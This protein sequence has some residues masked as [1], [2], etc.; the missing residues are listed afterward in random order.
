MLVCSCNICYYNFQLFIS[1]VM[2][3]YI[4]VCMN[5]YI[6]ICFRLGCRCGWILI[7]CKFCSNGAKNLYMLPTQFSFLW[8]CRITF[9]SIYVF[10]FIFCW[11][12][13]NTLLFEKTSF[14][15]FFLLLGIVSIF[16]LF[17][18][19]NMFVTTGLYDFF[20][21]FLTIGQFY[22]WKTYFWIFILSW[23]CLKEGLDY[24]KEIHST[25]PILVCLK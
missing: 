19:S 1:P 6:A 18:I 7:D 9:P 23:N 5:N 3:W 15:D 2:S 10:S 20:P 11:L 24:L 14:M 16:S 4:V 13:I 22:F 12:H 21:F 17:S 8:Y 25:Q